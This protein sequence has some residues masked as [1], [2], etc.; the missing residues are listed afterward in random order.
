MKH[1]HP[2]KYVSRK[3]KGGKVL[4][5]RPL[6]KIRKRSYF[7]GRELLDKYQTIDPKK[8]EGK[9][10]Y[11]DFWGDVRKIEH[12]K[13]DK[14]T[15]V[16]V[17][18]PFAGE[19][20]G[21]HLLDKHKKEKVSSFKP[22]RGDAL[23]EDRTDVKRFMEL[24]PFTDK[25]K[26]AIAHPRTTRRAREYEMDIAKEHHG[27][28]DAIPLVDLGNARKIN[29]GKKPILSEDDE[30]EMEDYEKLIEQVIRK[31]SIK[32]RSILPASLDPDKLTEKQLKN[33]KQTEAEN[34]IKYWLDQGLSR[35]EI[36]KAREHELR[37]QKL[38]EQLDK[39][40]QDATKLF[41]MGSGWS[42]KEERD[43]VNRQKRAERYA[44]AKQRKPIQYTAPI[45]IKEP[46]FSEKHPEMFSPIRKEPTPSDKE[47]W[48]EVNPDREA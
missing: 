20:R 1:R 6:H 44:E 37:Y 39:F 24:N 29:L 8:M 45:E 33:Q 13:G 32:K 41:S 19:E 5:R 7:S 46:S 18:T 34:Q 43:M 35:K 42:K 38:D 36:F 23:L 2:G 22:D 11:S 28:I 27:G 25:E 21:F 26:E 48:E 17:T 47:Y 31:R 30:K 40:K 15:T 14:M 3:P 9:F 16:N 10:I 4:K 12:V